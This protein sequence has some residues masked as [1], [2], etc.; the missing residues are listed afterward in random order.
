MM[1]LEK[2][3]IPA[4]PDY[5]P[6]LSVTESW[7][8][9][10]RSLWGDR[11]GRLAELA[12]KSCELFFTEIGM[13]VPGIREPGNR[14]IVHKDGSVLPDLGK[15]M[16]FNKLSQLPKLAFIVASTVNG[17]QINAVCGLAR[18]MKENGVKAVV[19]I[20]TSMA[21]ERQD[22]KFTDED[23]RQPIN[24]V[25]TLK[26]GIEI[27]NSY[28]DGA[29]LFQP[30]SFRAV[31][32]GLRQGIPILPIDGLA[33]LLQKSGLIGES[34]LLVLGPD[35]GRRDAA[36]VAARTLNSPLLTVEKVRDR[37]HGGRP[38][39]I[40]PEGSREWIKQNIRTVVITD[41]EIRDA[42]TTDVLTQDLLGYADDI[43]IIAP[44]AIMTPRINPRTIIREE[45][46]VVVR[47]ENEWIASST[48]EKL[49][50]PNIR[51]II[52]TDA[53]QPLVDLTLI[54]EK[55]RIFSL[56]PEIKALTDFLKSNWVPLS[57]D[58]LRNPRLTGTLLSLD[59]TVE[60]HS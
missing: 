5:S 10:A 2:S 41:D 21:H 53:I 33:F 32:F 56:K 22:H 30:H 45:R 25:T 7:G 37:L 42:G 34:G 51:E 55:I 3:I 58:W 48:A 9:R 49:N 31:E 27:L 23:T 28:C 59:L 39:I 12:S 26:D 40:W 54:S 4:V 14:L 60:K 38:K 16:E 13:S 19:P 17:E 35:V 36:R 20:L 43:R 52:I 29:L 44:K 46:L 6:E 1:D 18:E 8:G 57:P 50:K 11:L 15:L 47:P 24:Q